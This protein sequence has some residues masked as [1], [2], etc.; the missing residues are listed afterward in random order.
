VSLLVVALLVAAMLLL[1]A[2]VLV[3]PGHGV[4]AVLGILA[5]AGGVVLAF[6][7]LGPAWGTGA[8]LASAVIAGATLG[9]LPRTRLGRELV[10]S[11]RHAQGAA[12]PE[13]HALHGALGTALTALR[14]AGAAEFAG[15]RI[16][17]VSDGSFIEAGT[18]VRVVD[19]QGARVVV[20][21][22]D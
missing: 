12:R 10:L 15:E 11:K 6:A 5:L 19:V 14:P 4:G 2:E 9:L 1:V 20:E 17:V 13:L 18:T 8:V 3:I 16:D 22:T 7:E 21:A